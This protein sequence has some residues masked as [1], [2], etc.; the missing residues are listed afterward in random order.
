MVEPTLII[1]LLAA[2]LAG[3]VSSAI[4]VSHAFG[5]PDPRTDGSK[6]PGATNVLRLGGKLPAMLTLLG[7]AAKG[8]GPVLV[9][10]QFD[11][12][13]PWAGMVGLAAFLGHLFPLF[14]GFKGG[15]GVATL[16]GASF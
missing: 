8:F 5:L 16:I 1:A 2:Y 3:S 4:L 11:V 10:M 12:L 15:K 14:F 9:C 13:R 7:D 6:N